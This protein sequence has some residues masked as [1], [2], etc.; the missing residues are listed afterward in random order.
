MLN[1]VALATEIELPICA[2]FRDP[3]GWRAEPE[4]NEDD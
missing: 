1:E 2:A 4:G 3:R